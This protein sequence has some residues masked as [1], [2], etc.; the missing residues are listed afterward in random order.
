MK[1]IKYRYS[2]LAILLLLIPGMLTSCIRDELT[3]T[4]ERGLIVMSLDGVTTRD[5]GDPLNSG[6]AIIN[7]VRV[8][9]CVGQVLEVNKVFTAGESTFNNPFVLNVATGTKKIYVIANEP[10]E[11]TPILNDAI[12]TNMITSLITPPVNQSLTVPLTMVGESDPV[13]VEYKPNPPYTQVTVKLNRLATMINLKI[14]KG[15][16]ADAENIPILLKNVH[17]W[18]APKRSALTEGHTIEGQSYWNYK[19]EGQQQTYIEI[20]T[21]GIDAWTSATPMYLYENPGTVNDTTDRATY[22]T[23][24]AIYN[25]VNTSYHAYLNDATTSA[26]HHYSTKRNYQYDLV[27]TIN[28]IGEFEG[29]TLQT[30]VLPWNLWKSELVFERVYTISPQPTVENYTYTVNNT[31]DEV[32]FTFKLSNPMGAE[33]RAHL[34][35]PAEFE[36]STAGGA[37][38]QGL[39]GT[40]YTIKIKPR[41]PQDATARTTEFYITVGSDYWAWVEIPLIEGSI[42]VGPGNRVVI[43]QPAL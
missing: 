3:E 33:W 34:S 4:E 19:Y 24:D 10:D 17:I 36:F 1:R 7:K 21:D 26:D 28:D 22:L 6:D 16:Q 38:S 39:L 31:T 8:F 5:A 2:F 12:N 35:N 13:T 25:G 11:M 42:L 29:I 23:I 9:V 18:R 15:L 14:K 20:D 37:V 40:E 27:A 43:N 30:H 41:Q 32:T